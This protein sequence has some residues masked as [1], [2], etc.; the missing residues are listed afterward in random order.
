M[1]LPLGEHAVVPDEK[2]TG[3]C[4][5]PEHPDGRHKARVFSRALGITRENAEVLRAALQKAVRESDALEAERD[6]FGQRYLIDFS[7]TTTVGAAIVRSAWIVEK[8]GDPPRLL[9]CYVR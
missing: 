6:A 1:K 3:Y 2:L 9:S 4:L 8:S 7:L 5:N